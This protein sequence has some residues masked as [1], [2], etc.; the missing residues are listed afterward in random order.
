MFNVIFSKEGLKAKTLK[1]CSRLVQHFF[2]EFHML[3]TV[4]GRKEEQTALI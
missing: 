3:Y 4:V 2:L 1:L